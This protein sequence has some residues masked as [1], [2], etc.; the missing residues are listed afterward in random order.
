[1]QIACPSCKKQLRVP[2]TAAGKTV[3]CPGCGN[4]F[5]AVADVGQAVQ[6]DAPA[7]APKPAPPP[8]REEIEEGRPRPRPRDDDDD[9]LPRRSRRDYDDDDRVDDIRIPRMRYA[10]FWVRFGAAFLDGLL[11][12]AIQYPVSFA[13]NLG[14]GLP[15]IIDA[16]NLNPGDL[17]RVFA[18]SMITNVFS[19]VLGW[20]Y[21]ALMTSNPKF[22][23]T[24]GKMA[25]GVKVTDLNGDPIGFGRATGR[26]FA[27]IVSALILLIGFIM[28]AFHEKKQALHDQMAGTYVVYK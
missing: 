14:F 20:L 5:A 7:R 19:I 9:R 17:G 10:G 22:Q 24:L 4:T 21:E 1:M 18:A 8:I 27:K 26:H 2:D 25:V 23:G 28:A 3:K 6:A 12:A 16:G 15:L 13:I 11:M